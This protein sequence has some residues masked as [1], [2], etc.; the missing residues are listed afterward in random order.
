M[1]IKNIYRVLDMEPFVSCSTN[2][3]VYARLLSLEEGYTT[4]AGAN[5]ASI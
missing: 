4:H 3:S 5:S 2:C 1:D